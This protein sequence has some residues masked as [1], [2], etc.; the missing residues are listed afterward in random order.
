VNTTKKVKDRAGALLVVAQEAGLLPL[1]LEEQVTRK[2]GTSLALKYLVVAIT[3]LLE[4]C[5]L[6]K[7]QRKKL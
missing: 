6:N 2:E 5:T 7:K 1:I 4:S 3:N